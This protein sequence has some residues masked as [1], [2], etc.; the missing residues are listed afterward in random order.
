MKKLF[1]VALILT[2]SISCI[3][4][5]SPALAQTEENEKEAD[6]PTVVN[7]DN[8]TA[9]QVFAVNDTLMEEL[10]RL[11]RA[12]E[13]AEHQDDRE[14]TEAL[15]VKIRVIKEE[16]SNARREPTVTE[17]PREVQPV[18]ERPTV[19]TA[20][21]GSI[22]TTTPV[23]PC[24]EARALQEKK[25]YY[26]GLYALSD[27]ELQDKGY[28]RGKEELRVTIENLERSITRL[29][30][31]CEAGVS[32]SAGSGSGTIPPTETV[33]VVL[34]TTPKP[35]AVA[36]GGE[37]TEYYRIRLAEIALEEV[38]IDR[39]IARLIELR[40]EIDRLIEE[41]IKSKAEISTEEVSGL[42][43]R[44]QV[45]PG[46]V[47]MDKVVVKTV[48]KS[49]VT[50]MDNRE[51]SIRPA[52]AQ[53]IMRDENLEVRAP[54]LSIE[55]EVV[56][57]GNS[58]VNLR[59]AAVIEAIRVQPIEMELKEENATA[60]YRIRTDESRKLL[61]FIPIKVRKT[62]TVDATNTEV[63]IIDEERPWWAFFTTK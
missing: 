19:V 36:S 33:P 56:R 45:R 55:N 38:D 58:E 28:R 3:F 39:Q 11:V 59:P 1:S 42:V 31:E 49:I 5:M 8:Q 46:E 14:L 60:V 54:E 37:I 12:L 53:V 47:K 10:D 63:E 62:L 57:V 6:A 20:S 41:L 17:V 9:P 26:E 50:R 61:G 43:E 40:D 52:P 51:L 13:E 44:I 16:I 27:K 29:R 15:Q 35:V 23:D 32:G 7:S 24:E 22:V 2:V 21:E 25:R 18:N 34:I 48:D 30:A 4:G